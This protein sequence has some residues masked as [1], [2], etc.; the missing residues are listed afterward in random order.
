MIL[1]EVTDNMR[2]RWQV[3]LPLIALHLGA[4]AALFFF[5][6]RAAVLALALWVI[7]GMLGIT[8]GYHRLLNH[9]AFST[10][11]WVRRFHAV[12]ASFAL[13]QGPLDWV[14][15]HRAHHANAD[16]DRDPHTQRHGFWYGHM[17][18]PFLSFETLGRSKLLKVVPQD[19]AQDPWMVFLNR[20]HLHIVV[21]SLIGLYAWGGLPFLLWAGCF[22]IVFVMHVTW[23][24]NSLGHR[25][26]YTSYELEDLSTNNWFVA[27]LTFGEGWHN[28]HHRFPTSARQGLTPWEVDLSWYWISFLQKIGLAWDVQTPA[29]EQI[30]VAKRPAKRAFESV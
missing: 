5:D 11:P 21:A 17:G 8:V 16:T 12:C 26:G 19:L 23:A 2:I 30:S 9:N 4:F 24:V 20:F 13:Q 14:R 7:T 29:S 18:W 28:N 1:R 25:Y 10:Y 3:L 27:M 6:L 15:V 22:R